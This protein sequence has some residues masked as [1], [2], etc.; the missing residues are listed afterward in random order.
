MQY[1]I[2]KPKIGS[3]VMPDGDSIDIQYQ[4]QDSIVTFSDVR[5]NAMRSLRELGRVEDIYK[6]H[7][8]RVADGC[9]K[10]CEL[11]RAAWYFQN[12]PEC[13]WP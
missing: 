2:Q 4:S 9:C 3:L 6:G 12:K 7:V 10:F 13:I 1:P 5:S 11:S 8:F